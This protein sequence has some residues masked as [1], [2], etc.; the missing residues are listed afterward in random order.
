MR[1]LF[2][3]VLPAV[4]LT[5]SC[6]SSTTKEAT[7]GQRLAEEAIAIHDEIMPQVAVFDQTTLRI[8]SILQD[9]PSIAA[10][11]AN[12]DTT[13]LRSDLEELKANLEDATDF[14]MTWMYEYKPD[15]TDIAYQK[16]EIEKVT[17]MKK[18]FEDVTAE[19]QTKLS[20]F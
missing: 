15:S 9:L 3:I 6:Q 10:N 16:A 14:M 8:D 13:T 1:R 5:A 17:V 18:Q 2:N 19:S 12:L 4:I 7:E 11:N 20:S